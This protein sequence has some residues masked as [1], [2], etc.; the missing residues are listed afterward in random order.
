MSPF[1]RRALPFL[2]F[3]A[4][5]GTATSPRPR[6]GTGGNPP[7]PPGGDGGSSG[8]GGS[9]PAGTGGSA[10][11]G[12]S[13]TPD[14]APPPSSPDAASSSPDAPPVVG[15]AFHHPGVLGNKGQLDFVKAKIN[16][17]EQPWKAAYDKA[18]G[19]YGVMTYQATPFSNVECGS[20]SN[21]NNGCTEERNDGVAA[22]THALAWYV[23]G[24]EAHAKKAIEIMNAWSSTLKQ[25]TNSNGP[26]QAGWGGAIWPL[27]GEIIHSLYGKWP[28]FPA[29]ATMMKD[30]YLASTIKGSINNGNWELVMI[31]ASIEIAVLLDD[32][33][34]FDKALDMWRKRVPAYFYL[35]SDGP[36][37]VPPPAGNRTGAALIDYWAG[38]SVFMDGLSQE[39]CR[40]F[41]HTQYGI[42]SALAIA[43]TA[44]Q[45]GVDLYAEQS[46]RLRTTMEFHADYLTGKA[47]PANLC[48]GNLSRSDVLPT[49]E[50][51]YNHFHDRL[52]MALPLTQ[53]LIETRVRATGGVDHH[54]V[55]ETVTHAG[56]ARAGF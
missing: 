25:H 44:F 53:K 45:Q 28:E 39:T 5:C 20:Y 40:D 9:A 23:T 41:V 33:A 8:T 29:F 1:S 22:Y 52:G 46:Q 19:K 48:G 12:G 54:M 37:P 50:I 55:W 51:G 31:E 3:L 26:L 15:G 16:A 43:E 49:W 21:P 14:A 17:G 42:A 27:G 36:T 34:T 6:P 32:R 18:M 30:V 56:T 47:A 38:Q 11:S 2:I 7:S 10:P 35:Q 24:D 13:G 4:A